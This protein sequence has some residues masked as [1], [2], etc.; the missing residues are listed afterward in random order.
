MFGMLSRRRFFAGALAAVPMPKPLAPGSGESALS[1]RAQT[2]LEIRRQAALAQSAR[3]SGSMKDNGDE[4]ALPARTGSF[5]KGLPQNQF[6]E[7]EP[8][9]YEALLAAV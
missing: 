5:T 2:A 6:G 3:P 7:V 4:D 8:K 9:A 1:P